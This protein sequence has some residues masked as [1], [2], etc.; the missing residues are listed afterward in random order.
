M[1]NKEGVICPKLLISH[2]IEGKNKLYSLCF[3]YLSIQ[4]VSLECGYEM[5]CVY[6]K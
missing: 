4:S 5:E 2:N 6:I 1:F 3:R